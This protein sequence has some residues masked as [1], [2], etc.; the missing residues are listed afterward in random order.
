MNEGDEVSLQFIGISSVLPE[1]G[2]DTACFV[3]DR[4]VLVDAGWCAALHMRSFGLEPLDIDHLIIT[5]G[6]HDHYLGLPQLLFYWGHIGRSRGGPNRPPTTIVGPAESLAEIVDRAIQL[7]MPE[8]FPEVLP[9]FR[10]VPLAPGETYEAKSFTLKACRACHP[11]PA[12]S[13]RY[14][15]AAGPQVAFSGDTAY[16]PELVDLARNADILIHEA[17]LGAREGGADNSWG[18]SGAPDAARIAAAAGVGKLLLIHCSPAERERA[19]AAAR[20]LFPH[21][22]LAAGSLE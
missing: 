20:A 17:S 1:P 8:R 19:L 12:L 13:Y 5:H 2:G 7:L 22:D 9:E 21:T 3:L 6:H 15:P 11:V 18:H 4:H 16:N 10:L 14:I